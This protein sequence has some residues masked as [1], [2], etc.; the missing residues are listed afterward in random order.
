MTK[1]KPLVLKIL[2]WT[3]YLVCSILEIMLNIGTPKRKECFLKVHTLYEEGD[4]G[5]DEY[6][7]RTKI[8]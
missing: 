8:D 7:R 3:L 6:L 4:I 5:L 1:E 2:A